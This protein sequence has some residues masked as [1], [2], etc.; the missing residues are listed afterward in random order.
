[1]CEWYLGGGKYDGCYGFNVKDVISFVLVGIGFIVGV[2]VIIFIWIF[3]LV[4]LVFLGFYCCFIEDYLFFLVF[5]SYK[6][7]EYVFLK[8]YWECCVY[9]EV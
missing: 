7:L 2:I 1:M 4:W 3:L 6:V 5:E 8:S 9:R